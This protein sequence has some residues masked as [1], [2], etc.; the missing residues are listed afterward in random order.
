[1]ANEAAYVALAILVIVVAVMVWNRN[2]DSYSRFEGCQSACRHEEGAAN[3]DR[4]VQTCLGRRIMKYGG[5]H[6]SSDDDCQTDQVCVL[7]GFYTGKDGNVY[8]NLNVGT[9]MDENDPGVVQ[10][11]QKAPDRIPDLPS[12]DRPGK[13]MSKCLSE[14]NS[15]AG[16]QVLC[17]PAPAFPGKLGDAAQ[18]L[19][20][21]GPS[22]S[23]ASRCLSE[24]G[25]PS[26][27]RS[28]CGLPGIPGECMR[29]CR[30]ERGSAAECRGICDPPVEPD[31]DD[32]GDNPAWSFTMS[33]EITPSKVEGYGSYQ[34]CPPGQYWNAYAA[35]GGGCANIFSGKS[36][37]AYVNS[38]KPDKSA[39]IYFPGS[40]LP[41]YGVGKK[42]PKDQ[43][44]GVY[45]SSDPGYGRRN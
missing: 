11:K 7:G 29:R 16:C 35:G 20:G 27:C 4:C 26:L 2:A 41:A 21:K 30:S 40:T 32:N 33:G 6:C 38:Q 36:S 3:R 18:Y 13:C 45:I 12:H 23:C 34:A 19:K 10:W 15:K 28:L 25:D 44:S 9:C 42:D 37:A 39:E 31:D 17:D 8:P 24:R 22:V 14:G 1:M 5:Q 43:P